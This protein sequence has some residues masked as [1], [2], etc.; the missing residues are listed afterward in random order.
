[1]IVNMFSTSRS[2]VKRRIRTDIIAE[3][4]LT[5]GDK[6]RA[7]DGKGPLQKVAATRVKSTA[8][9]GSATKER[10]RKSRGVK[11]ACGKQA[12]AI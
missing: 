1:M 3:N 4:G 2:L 6:E 8:K 9:Y 10:A 7:E 11:L 12:A 5:A